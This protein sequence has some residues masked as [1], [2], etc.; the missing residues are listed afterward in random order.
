MEE[1]KKRK[2]EL[3]EGYV[4]NACGLTGHAIYECELYKKKVQKEKKIKFFLWG[5]LPTTTKEQ[6]EEFLNQND[7]SES[8]VKLV[9][10]NNRCKGVGFVTINQ[11]ETEKLLALNGAQ[12]ESITFNVKKDS[13]EPSKKSISKR[14]FRCGGQHDS[15]TCENPRICYRC[16]STE[17]ISSE[18][19]LKKSSK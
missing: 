14:C 11:S 7:I 8:S 18:C 6:L 3:P 10:N 1:G 4:C 19:P 13:K 2:R 12:F 5:L 16:K 9:M 17:H 15:S